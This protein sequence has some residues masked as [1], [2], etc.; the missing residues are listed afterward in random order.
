VGGGR[1]HQGRQRRGEQPG[2]P[3][4]QH[5]AAR[6]QQA[7]VRERL[8]AHYENVWL[9]TYWKRKNGSTGYGSGGVA[10]V[11]WPRGMHLPPNTDPRNPAW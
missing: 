4:G 10:Y 6:V 5:R 9:R 1:L 3:V 11:I 8:A 7:A 2:E